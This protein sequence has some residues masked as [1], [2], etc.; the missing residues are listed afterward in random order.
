MTVAKTAA[1]PGELHPVPRLLLVRGGGKCQHLPGVFRL[2]TTQQLSGAAT[3]KAYGLEAAWA[4]QLRQKVDTN[5]STQVMC[6]VSSNRPVDLMAGPGLLVQPV[7]VHPTG[8][9]GQQHRVGRRAAGRAGQGQFAAR[10]GGAGPVLRNADHTDT[11]PAHPAD[12]ADREQHGEQSETDHQ[13]H[14]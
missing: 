3:I 2:V 10:A 14:Q 11:Q 12:R 6:A 5:N 7:V 4:E 9:A 8:V 13:N 1:A